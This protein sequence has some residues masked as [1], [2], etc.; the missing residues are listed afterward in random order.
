[1]R[2]TIRPL[3]SPGFRSSRR[4]IE[5]AR[6]IAV[7]WAVVA[8]LV[9]TTGASA[10]SP[11]PSVNAPPTARPLTCA[12]RYPADGPGG[13]DL[14]LGCV[15]NELVA[16]AGG[17][18][19]SDQP[20]RLTAYVVP[21]AAVALALVALVLV[22]RQLNRRADR[23]IAPA[24]PVAWWPCPACRSLNVARRETCYRCG[25]PLESGTAEMRTDAEPP[26]PQSFGRRFN[27]GPRKDGP[28]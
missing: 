16:Y 27:G 25:R 13:V 8:F 10:A 20:Q 18:G 3:T 19:P 23:W 14:Q 28:G 22:A 11:D 12:E 9:G 5:G 15:V 26:A 1:M 4:A 21:I 24:A 2:L 7:A 6:H 17:L